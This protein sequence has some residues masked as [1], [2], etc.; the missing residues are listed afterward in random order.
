MASHRSTSESPFPADKIGAAATVDD[1]RDVVNLFQEYQ[2]HV[3]SY[4]DSTRTSQVTDD[5]DFLE[6]V[7][8]KLESY[9]AMHN[10]L[11]AALA[12]HTELPT[13]TKVAEDKDEANSSIEEPRRSPKKASTVASFVPPTIRLTPPAASNTNV[14]L[15]PAVGTSGDG[16]CEPT[17]PA[18]SPELLAM[19]RDMAMETSRLDYHPALQSPSTQPVGFSA[20]GYALYAHGQ[21]AYTNEASDSV[22]QEETFDASPATSTEKV[23][24]NPNSAIPGLNVN[25]T[26]QGDIDPEASGFSTADL[27][28]PD[29]DHED[30]S[31]SL[32][33]GI[34]SLSNATMTSLD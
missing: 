32:G 28:F 20:D 8:P 21:D 15:V 34:P 3:R 19:Y 10:R 18:I 9:V 14:R 12:G 1:L 23:S 33:S 26:A 30:A 25:E 7:A 17:M 6:Y 5:E 24:L 11:R 31:T 4:L 27:V 13:L 16:E 22:M 2:T 29:N